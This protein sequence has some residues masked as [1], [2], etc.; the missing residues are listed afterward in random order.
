[1]ILLYKCPGSIPTLNQLC[2]LKFIKKFKASASYIE[3]EVL[4]PPPEMIA[5]STHFEFISKLDRGKPRDVI[6]TLPSS[7]G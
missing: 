1:M 2:H 4:S 7:V 3:S 5:A 6:L